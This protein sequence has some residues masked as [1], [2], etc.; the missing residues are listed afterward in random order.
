MTQTIGTAMYLNLPIRNAAAA[1]RFWSDVGVRISEA[2]SDENAVALA[3]SKHVVAMLLQRD[4]Y[5]EFLP[6]G[7]DIADTSV[8]S[9][10][11]ICLDADSLEAVDEFVGAA[12]SAG[13]TEVPPSDPDPAQEMI[14]A[15]LMYG[16]TFLD[17][18]GHQWEILWMSSQMPEG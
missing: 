4:F 10:C 1:R 7:R 12:L 5:R 3:F 11:L 8:S 6:S 2:Y 9:G 18:D 14:D 15:G 16:R 17:P 13:G